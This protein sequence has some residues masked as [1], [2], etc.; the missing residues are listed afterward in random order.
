MHCPIF[1][2]SCMLII[3]G[4]GAC[5]TWN[6][7]TEK[8]KITTKQERVE[9]GLNYFQGVRFLSIN[10]YLLVRPVTLYLNEKGIQHQNYILPRPQNF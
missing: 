6:E 3:T 5:L 10:I 8:K 1:T 4:P 9:E 7:D 2:L